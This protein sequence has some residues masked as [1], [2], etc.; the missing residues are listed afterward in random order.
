MTINK[1]S[2]VWDGVYNTFAEAA[3]ESTVFEGSIWLDKIVA[4]ASA[5]IDAARQPAAIS[6]A[7]VTTDSA[8][9]F[10]AALVARRDRPLRI[11]DFGGGAGTGFV[12]LTV[13]L[14]EGQ[15]LDFVVV[16]NEAICRVGRDLFAGDPRVS[17]VTELPTHGTF[18][19]VYAG[20]A[21]HYVDDWLDKLAR[22]AALQPQYVLFADLPAGDI[23]TFVTA[24]LF[25]GSRIPVRFWN[26]SEFV[27]SMEA[28]GYELAFKARY[29]GYYL[30]ADTELP[31]RNFDPDHR[32][33][34]CSQLIFRRRTG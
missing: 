22:F 12:P 34:Y 4:R 26:F 28:H 31:T 1:T 13:M 3:A 15:P 32:L 5:L 2:N 30:T 27:T 11:L 29:R 24:Q 21:I 20:S 14:P 9:P 17:F 7:A 23:K 18:D 25:H 19:I 33:T 6:P 8:L 16:E 10:V